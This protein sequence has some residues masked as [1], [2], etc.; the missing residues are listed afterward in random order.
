EDALV[1]EAQGEDIAGPVTDQAGD[2]GH[3]GVVPAD[4]AAAG[5]QLVDLMGR[6]IQPEGRAGHVADHLVA[7]G[8][9]SVLDRLDGWSGRPPPMIAGSCSARKPKQT[10]KQLS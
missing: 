1:L 4:P 8:H 5:G 3:V 2:V 6:W 9:Q 10:L 7:A